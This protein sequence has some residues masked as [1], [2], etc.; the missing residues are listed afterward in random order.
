MAKNKAKAPYIREFNRFALD[1]IQ[2]VWEELKEPDWLRSAMNNHM[3]DMIDIVEFANNA[4]YIIKQYVETGIYK[5]LKVEHQEGDDIDDYYYDPPVDKLWGIRDETPEE[6]EARQ[7]QEKLEKEKKR[8]AAKEEKAKQLAK[9][10]E[11]FE[12]LKKK[13]EEK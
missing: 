5:T 6:V 8:A 2:E 12:R 1:G 11:T 3:N 10:R 4:Q 7:A 13:F 9:E